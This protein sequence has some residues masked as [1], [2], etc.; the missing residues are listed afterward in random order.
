MKE[1]SCVAII[2]EGRRNTHGQNKQLV[3]QSRQKY[4]RQ[5]TELQENNEMN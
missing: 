1:C 2:K 3:E 5:K 4:K